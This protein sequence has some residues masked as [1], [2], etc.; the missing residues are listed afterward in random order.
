MINSYSNINSNF[1]EFKKGEPR[2][3][4][5]KIGIGAY[6]GRIVFVNGNIYN[7]VEA[8]VTLGKKIAFSWIDCDGTSL[9]IGL[10]KY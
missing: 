5:M 3:L 8:N 7:V 9:S 2:I 6:L 1:R 4:Y 10:V